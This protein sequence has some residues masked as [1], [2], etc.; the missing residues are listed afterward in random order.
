M[1]LGDFA[2]QC[3][4]DPSI[5]ETFTISFLTIVNGPVGSGEYVHVLYSTPVSQGRFLVQFTVTRTAAGLE[6]QAYVVGGTSAKLLER[7]GPFPGLNQWVY[8][9]I[10]Y[11]RSPEVI[12]LYMNGLKTSNPLLERRWN[13]S[14]S[15]VEV[16]LGSRNNTGQFCVSYLQVTKVALTE[17]EVQQL[18]RESRAHGKIF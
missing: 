4:G 18:E 6:G 17:D 13:S 16:S 9:A 5:C 12:E 1:I 10:V 8:V 3:L 2:S 7:K 14:G 15:D 11:S